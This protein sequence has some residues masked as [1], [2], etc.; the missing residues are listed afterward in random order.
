M[1]NNCPI[2]PDLT[3]CSGLNNTLDDDYFNCWEKVGCHQIF[4]D[5]IFTN[6]SG[7][8]EYNLNG[9]LNAQAAATTLLTKYFTSYKLTYPNIAGYN[10]FQVQLYNLCTDSANTPGVCQAY[11]A[12]D[13]SICKTKTYDQMSTDFNFVN[14][15]SCFIPPDSQSKQVY[16]SPVN[17][18]ITSCS[19]NPTTI[20]YQ[21][22]NIGNVPC[23][24]LCHQVESIQLYQPDSGCKYECNS[25]VCIISDV[26][27]NQKDATGNTGTVR[28]T[29]VC[30]GCTI[31]NECVCII[32]SSDLQDSM[33]ELGIRSSF[34]Q[35]CGYNA[36][37]YV[38]DETGNLQSVPC[39]DY[40][41][42]A[43]LDAFKIAIPWIFIG[44][45][46]FTI[47]VFMVVFF[48]TRKANVSQATNPLDIYKGK[49]VTYDGN[50]I[51][52]VS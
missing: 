34:N 9:L 35:Y 24:P 25:D 39:G 48:A 27:I 17:A 42:N 16:D 43:A 1:S 37:C 49:T 44:L 23:Y 50:I 40:L 7:L 32:S 30:P 26:S 46:I 8:R 11:L 52:S 28:F 20:T 22:E 15:C 5:A 6:P 36:N 19:P 45:A 10:P 3:Y 29:Q 21:G 4:S 13:T 33:K 51:T 38:I 41:A 18:V 47:I 2:N 12:G 14:W 31:H